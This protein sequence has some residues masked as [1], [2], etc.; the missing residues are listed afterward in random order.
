MRNFILVLCL[1]LSGSASTSFAN[2]CTNGS[3]SRPVL[4]GVKT[5]L[6][7]P[8]RITRRVVSLPSRVRYNRTHR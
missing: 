8:V 6:T 4:N 5:V 3:C 1:I 7:V 2:S